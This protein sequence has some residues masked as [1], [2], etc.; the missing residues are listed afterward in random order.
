MRLV[1]NA[2]VVVGEVIEQAG[3]PLARTPARQVSGVVFDPGAASHLEQHVDVEVRARLQPLRL[4]QLVL[5]HKLGEPL[6]QLRPDRLYRPLDRRPLGDEVRGRIDGAAAQ[7][8]DRVPGERVDLGDAVDRVAPELDAHG[9]LVVGGEHFDGIAPHAKRAALERDV[10]ALVLHPH[11]LFEQGVPATLLPDRRRDQQL[12]VQL[13]VAEAV[14][15]RDARHDDH[16]VPLHQAR[17]GAEPQAVDIVV[18]GRILGDVRVG[19]GHV[20]FWLVVVIVGDE[21]L[22]RVPGKERL[23]LSVQLGGEG[24]VVR[25][26]ERGTPEPGDDVRHCERLPRPRDAQEHLVAV[27]ADEALAQLANGAR[28]IPCGG[29]G[30]GEVERHPWKVNRRR[31]AP[32]VRTSRRSR[33]GSLPGAT[34]RLRPSPGG[35]RG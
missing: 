6:L 27:V 34:H 14:D 20:R 17:R 23:Q 7:L 26:H 29:V 32:G 18:D 24:L 35:S 30:G 9:L 11:E 16:I 25:Q 10:I 22:D 28:L 2:E 12:A 8:G 15:R 33:G 4:Q 21:E 5:R 1:D 3:R 31:A 19:L 13:R